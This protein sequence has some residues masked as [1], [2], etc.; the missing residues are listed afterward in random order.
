M[1]KR[2]NY[3]L[4]ALSAALLA[5]TAVPSFA[6]SHREAPSVTRFPKTDNTDTYLFRSYEPGRDGFVT[7]LANYQPL[8]DPYGGPSY[9]TMD[10][11][12]IYEIHIDNNGDARED[13]TF[14]FRF[15]NT[16]INNGQGALIPVGN[17]MIPFSLRATGE[18]LTRDDTDL[19]ERESYTLTLVRGDRR[20]GTRTPVMNTTTPGTTFFKPLDN[21]GEKTL[22]RYLNYINTGGFIANMTFDGC[23]TAGRVFAGQR[24]EAFS[25]NLGPVFDLVNFVPI[26]GDSAPGAGD[27]RGFGNTVAG[28]GPGGNA[29]G[30]TQDR[31]NDD[32]VGEHNV[33]TLALEL[34]IS[35]IVQSPTQPIIGAWATASLPQA[36]LVDPTPNFDTANVTGGAFVQVSRLATP[37]ANELLVG[38]TDKDRF[39]ASEPVNDPQFLRYVTNPALPNVLNSLFLDAVNGIVANL[40]ANGANIPNFANLQPTN[41]PRNDL[42]AA[43]LTGIQGLNQPPSVVPGEMLRLNTSTPVTLRDN[44]STF[45]V[46]GGDLAGFPNGRRPGDDGVDLILRVAMGRLCHPLP[47][48]ANGAGVNLGLCTPADAPTGLVAYTDGAPISAMELLNAFPYLQT[49]MP[50][51]PRDRQNSIGRDS[52]AQ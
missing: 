5:T 18:V 3:G 52:R 39:N 48:G 30:I 9:F 22:P 1:K 47:I 31:D 14:Q 28:T 34:P 29:P 26:E 45:G 4:A 17:M 19:A 43:A 51:S 16:L 37:L 7:I 46:A 11:T 23:A 33:T 6:S 50:G 20:T 2:L 38:I 40:R 36:Q 8:Q 42:V 15:T 12:A 41:F 44:Q 32:L 10:P 13:L 27:R 21:I 25:V 35:C 49:P 24:A